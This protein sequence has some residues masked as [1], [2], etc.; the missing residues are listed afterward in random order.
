MRA[1]PRAHPRTARALSVRPSPRHRGV[2]ERRAEQEQRRWVPACAGTT[3]SC[4]SSSLWLSALLCVRS[5]FPGPSRP[6]RGREGNSRKAG[7]G[8]MPARSLSGHGWPVSEPPQRP[9]EVAG[10][11]GDRGRVGR[12]S[13]VT[14]SG[15]TE[16]V[17]RPPGRRT[18]PHTDVSRSSSL[19][20]KNKRT[21]N[22]E[23]KKDQ[24]RPHPALSR[25]RERE[26]PDNP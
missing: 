6:R 19:R 26:K 13:L 21:S 5:C 10:F 9:R 16:K 18:K 11:I 24:E 12:L 15:E 23:P 2:C 14:F 1:I 25:K 17:T 20:L 22:S 4:C 8:T 7:A 3:K